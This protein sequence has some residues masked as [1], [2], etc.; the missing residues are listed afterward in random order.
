MKFHPSPP[1]QSLFIFHL[2]LK[3]QSLSPPK[4]QLTGI[5]LVN[6]SLALIGNC[7]FA[8]EESDLPYVVKSPKDGDIVTQG[9]QDFNGKLFMSMTAHPNEQI[10]IYYH[11][12]DVY[13]SYRNQQISLGTVLP[14][15]YQGHKDVTVW[16]PFLYATTIPMSPFVLDFLRQD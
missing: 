8:L 10:G 16:S 1:S 12:L 2:R 5:G 6:T 11:K 7:L 13:T 15:T 3:S 4:I 9:C 14:A